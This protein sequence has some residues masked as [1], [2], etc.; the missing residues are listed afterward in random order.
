L[1]SKKELEADLNIKLQ[2]K[3]FLITFH[4]ET[5]DP[6]KAERHFQ[7]LL[8]VLGSQKNTLLVFTF[9]NA[10]TGYK[11]LLSRLEGFVSN[12]ENAVLFK[13]LG[14]LRYLS[15]MKHSDA[16]V[17]N[18]SSGIIEAPSFRIATINIGNRQEGRIRANSIIDCT[19]DIES[20]EKAFSKL[21]SASFSEKVKNSRNPYG[22]GG[23]SEKVIRHLKA[24]NIDE[25]RMKKFH[26]IK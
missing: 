23:A 25:L 12:N 24:A 6:E 22:K 9:P 4:P 19:P 10:D 13:S 5:K 3:N 11:A 21:S 7:N 14:Q 2:K 15:L 8:T 20:I 18:S 26:D 17:G 16:V 1:L